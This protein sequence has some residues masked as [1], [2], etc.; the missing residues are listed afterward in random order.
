MP[1]RRLLRP[2]PPLPCLSVLHVSLLHVSLLLFLCCCCFLS[3]AVSHVQSTL[4]S[5]CVTCSRVCWVVCRRSS[6][7]WAGST[8]WAAATQH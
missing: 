4:S 7:M 1:T 6:C 2:A 3:P 8:T 5:T